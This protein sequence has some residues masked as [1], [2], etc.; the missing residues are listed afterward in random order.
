[1][2]IEVRN[3]LLEVKSSTYPEDNRVIRRKSDGQI[4]GCVVY[5]NANISSLDDYEEID[6]PIEEEI[7]E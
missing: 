4:F 5:A 1:M 3:E 6:K 7:E 2:I